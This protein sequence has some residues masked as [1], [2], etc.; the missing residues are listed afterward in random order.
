MQGLI[1]RMVSADAMLRIAQT[2]ECQL[3]KS[4]TES[5]TADQS[6]DTFLPGLGRMVQ[7]ERPLGKGR[8]GTL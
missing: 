5:F 8:E 4:G 3:H 2:P 1:V 7:V 6:R